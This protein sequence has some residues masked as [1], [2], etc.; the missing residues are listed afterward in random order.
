MMKIK[1]IVSITLFLT[2][3]VTF[4]TGVEGGESEGNG[5]G[6]GGVHVVSATVLGLLA[7]VHILLNRRMLVNQLKVLIGIK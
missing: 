4:L 1:G 6:E 5:I 7:V 3:A 2:L